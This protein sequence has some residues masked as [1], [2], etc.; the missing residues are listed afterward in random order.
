MST[1][2]ERLRLLTP[3]HTPKPRFIQLDGPRQI[4][5]HAD[6]AVERGSSPSRIPRLA[7]PSSDSQHIIVKLTLPGSGDTNFEQLRKLILDLS[8]P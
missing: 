2:F 7:P 3:G 4:V 8:V 5:L 6:R 1:L